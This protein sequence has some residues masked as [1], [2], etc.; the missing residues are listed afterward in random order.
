MRLLQPAI[1]FGLAFALCI[2]S[3]TSLIAAET[4]AAAKAPGT[5]VA[6]VSLASVE[7]LLGEMDYVFASA[8]RPEIANFARGLLG[9]LRDLKGLDR[10]RPLGLMIQMQDAVPQG[11]AFIPVKDREEL[12]KTFSLG[13]LS[14]VKDEGAENRWELKGGQKPA[15]L[16]V[17]DAWV[18]VSDRKDA[19][20]DALPD[21][22]AVVK[23]LHESYDLAAEIDFRQV[24]E[25]ARHLL[26]DY[27]RAVAAGD[28]KEPKAG[29][30]QAAFALRK[31]ATE[32]NLD[33][34]DRLLNQGA[35]ATFGWSL[36]K[37]ERA[38][39]LD[40]ALTV[41]PETALDNQVRD[42]AGAKSE[43]TASLQKNAP[44]GA[45]GTVL[46]DEPARKILGQLLDI[47]EGKILSSIGTGKG[48]PDHPV[49]KIFRSLAAT[50][51]A[52]KL[53]GTLQIV[54]TPPGP[55]VLLGGN[56]LTNGN[57][58]AGGIREIIEFMK[59][60]PNL[61]EVALD[62]A[63]VRGVKLHRLKPAHM[64]EQDERLY[65]KDAVIL[66]GAGD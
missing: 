4:T 29:E 19:L 45:A 40:L 6:V 7:R 18:F 38:A 55:F 10:E 3:A 36:N 61:S 23:S 2:A 65:G 52:G 39:R 46:L 31:L 41:K 54:G 15:Y 8:E 47:G 64:K 34:L 49:E 9:I 51:A 66:L 58:V 22:G 37:Q 14:F 35:R 50:V 33:G 43:Y 27:L 32:T 12:F 48:N 44:L 30:E 57:L 26:V 63:E 53:D 24:P 25:T 28:L 20:T 62:A 5:P 1:V 21:P 16:L 60:D 42:Y 59:N 17:R 13:P 56:A 11:V